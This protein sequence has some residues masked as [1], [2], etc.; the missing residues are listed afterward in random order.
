ML[1]LHVV[2]VIIIKV[3]VVHHDPSPPQPP[4]IVA[5]AAVDHDDDILVKSNGMNLHFGAETTDRLKV[6][7]R[8]LDL[9]VI[10]TRYYNDVL[11]L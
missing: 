7:V 4:L 8:L 2:V 10:K 9:P 5:A 11:T 1:L 6:I 3:V